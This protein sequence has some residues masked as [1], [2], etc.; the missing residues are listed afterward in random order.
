M[1]HLIPTVPGILTTLPAR[2]LAVSLNFVSLPV[3][4]SWKLGVDPARFTLLPFPSYE[5]DR[6]VLE[7]RT[8]RRERSLSVYWTDAGIPAYLLVLG[9]YIPYSSRRND[10]HAGAPQLGLG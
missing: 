4:G 5:L 2:A 10:L 8:H 9:T 1:R 3:I 6:L 7:E